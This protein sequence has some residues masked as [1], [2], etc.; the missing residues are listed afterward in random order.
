MKFKRLLKGEYAVLALISS[1]VILLSC[2]DFTASV[3]PYHNDIVTITDVNA[4]V[5]DADVRAGVV[6]T[7]NSVTSVTMS[8]RKHQDEKVACNDCH[9]KNKNDDRVKQCAKCHK[10]NQG[11]DVMHTACIKCHLTKR[12]G[13]TMCQECHIP[14]KEKL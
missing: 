10:G 11:R 4:L 3:N 6:K 8:H 2:G 12:V 14:V 1:T 7:K 5:N 9:H 13:L